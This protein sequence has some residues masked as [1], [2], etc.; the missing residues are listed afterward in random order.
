MY[1]AEI[2]RYNIKSSGNLS[3]II[4]GL[5]RKTGQLIN[6]LSRFY[7]SLPRL[8]YH[9]ESDLNIL[10]ESVKEALQIM[11]FSIRPK[12]VEEEGRMV[13]DL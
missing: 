7:E 9:R 5:G 3:P 8:S 12:L 10:A 6:N 4:D 1:Q 13:W 11:E 2:N